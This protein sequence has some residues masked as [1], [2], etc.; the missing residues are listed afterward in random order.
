MSVKIPNMCVFDVETKGIGDPY[1]LELS[2]IALVFMED[3][4]VRFYGENEIDEGIEQLKLAEGI[5]GFN[6]RRFDVPVCLKYMSRGEGRAFRAKPHLDFLH[7]MML[8]WPGQRAGLDNFVKTT[9]HGDIRKFDL[10]DTSAARLNRVDPTLLRAYN[11][12]DTYV[13]YLLAVHAF[14]HGWVEFTLPVRRRMYLPN[15]QRPGND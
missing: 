8:L 2:G 9:F 7:E 15:L 3:G 11:I 5:V 4:K 13:T 12:W 14:T 10:Y 6:S 1:E